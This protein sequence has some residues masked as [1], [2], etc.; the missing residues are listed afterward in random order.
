MRRIQL[1]GGS[2]FRK[3]SPALT[4]QDF[5]SAGASGLN[6]EHRSCINLDD[7]ANFLGSL[8][9]PTFCEWVNAK[10]SLSETCGKVQRYQEPGRAKETSP[11]SSAAVAFRSPHGWPQTDIAEPPTH[12]ADL[13]VPRKEH[14]GLMKV[15]DKVLD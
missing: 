14:I 3:A 4:H 5:R 6:R 13:L 7:N 10:K 1:K 9:P 11:T 12:A 8:L 2:P 15:V